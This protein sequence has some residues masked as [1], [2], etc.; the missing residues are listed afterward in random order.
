MAADVAC[1][2]TC[3][4]LTSAPLGNHHRHTSL[5]NNH[6]TSRDTVQVPPVVVTL[7]HA[8][9]FF[10]TGMAGTASVTL[11]PSITQHSMYSHALQERLR[12]GLQAS[13][14]ASTGGQIWGWGRQHPGT[15]RTSSCTHPLHLLSL[16]HTGYSKGPSIPS[17]PKLQVGLHVTDVVSPITF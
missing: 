10:G 6:P 15:L 9:L 5:Y 13:F 1:G 14:G 2:D 7:V 11:M 17:P 3:Q 8:L 16:S 4:Q 12:R